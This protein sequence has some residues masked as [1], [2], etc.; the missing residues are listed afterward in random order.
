[1]KLFLIIN[2]VII[3]F[4]TCYFSLHFLTCNSKTNER[5]LLSIFTCIRL[6]ID[7][8]MN[9]PHRHSLKAFV[10]FTQ[11]SVYACVLLFIF[12]LKQTNSLNSTLQI[13]MDQLRIVCVFSCFVHLNKKKIEFSKCS[14]QQPGWHTSFFR[15]AWDTLDH[16][17]IHQ[18]EQQHMACIFQ[19]FCIH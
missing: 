15:K 19:L 17:A 5:H 3:I 9:E 16:R 2:A 14:R 18:L 7:T 13:K 4:E 11:K 12:C 1:M 6:A 8:V 10:L